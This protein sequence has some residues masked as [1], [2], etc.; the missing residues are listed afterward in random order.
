MAVD[1]VED[2]TA[3]KVSVE[4]QFQR[5]LDAGAPEGRP[6]KA[7]MTPTPENIVDLVSTPPPPSPTLVDEEQA[8]VQ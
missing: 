4:T 5:Y 7:K 8:S 3:N 1:I 6:K 2:A